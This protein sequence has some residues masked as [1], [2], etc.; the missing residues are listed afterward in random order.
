VEGPGQSLF[1]TLKNEFP[2]MPFV[3]EDL[4]KIDR[5]VYD[6]RDNYGLPG[7]KVLQFAFGD[8]TP[9][10]PHITH[11]HGYNS[12]AYTGTH[13]NNTARGWFRK[14]ADSA[15]KKKI[16]Q[17]T[18]IK[19][20]EK[21]CHEVILRIC[22]SSPAKIAI[23]PVQDILGLDE[24]SRMNTPSTTKGNWLWKLRQGQLNVS[25]IAYLKEITEI[26]GRY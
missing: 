19:V 20:K 10:Q 6:L 2:E 14:E 26:F 23:A 15:M 25:S 16:E 21:N 12:I 8:N 17:Y 18:G 4:G 5:A 22:F 1:D 13:D 7:M 11:N 9:F 3:A 24:K